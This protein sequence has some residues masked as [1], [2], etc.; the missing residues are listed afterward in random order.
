MVRTIHLNSL[1]TK[2]ILIHYQLYNSPSGHILFSN[3][4]K[5]GNLYFGVLL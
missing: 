4:L 5:N 3:V 2:K 1:I